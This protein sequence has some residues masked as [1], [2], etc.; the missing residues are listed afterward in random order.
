MIRCTLTLILC[1]VTL[2]ARAQQQSVVTEPDTK[3]LPDIAQLLDDVEKHEDRDDAL[4][5]QYTYHRHVVVEEY[6]GD[7]KTITSDYESIPIAGVRVG[8]LVARDGK[9]L[10]SDE[11][12]KVNEDFDKAVEKAKKNKA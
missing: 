7:K 9:P 1:I 3:P 6:G 2:Y 4:L 12:K 5:Q 11:A 10:S 8:K